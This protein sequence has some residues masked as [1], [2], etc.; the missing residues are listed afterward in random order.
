LGFFF[1]FSFCQILFKDLISNNL[2]TQ[3]M[4]PFFNRFKIHH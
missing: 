4:R 2:S 3:S 1:A